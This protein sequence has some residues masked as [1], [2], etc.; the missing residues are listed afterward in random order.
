MRHTIAMTL[1]ELIRILKI[2]DR[3][4]GCSFR[5]RNFDTYHERDE[6][7]PEESAGPSEIEEE[8]EDRHEPQREAAKTHGAKCVKIIP[9]MD[10]T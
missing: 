3:W 4:V 9:R 5:R 2:W 10:A 7:D 1:L 6:G 8:R